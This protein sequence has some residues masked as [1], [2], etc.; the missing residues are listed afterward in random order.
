LR[1]ERIREPAFVAYAAIDNLAWNS[2]LPEQ[3]ASALFRRN[4]QQ[5]VELFCTYVAE[6]RTFLFS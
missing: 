1:G 2:T 4:L 5:L 6:R 3:V